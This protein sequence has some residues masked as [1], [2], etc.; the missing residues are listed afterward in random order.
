MGEGND[1]QPSLHAT[2]LFQLNEPFPESYKYL[3]YG[4][5]LTLP[6]FLTFLEEL[7]RD[8]GVL[9]FV[10]Y[11]MSL[12]FS[13]GAPEDLET[14]G[15]V[16]LR[17]ERIA[18][19]VGVLKSVPKNRSTEIGYEFLLLSLSALSR[20]VQADEM[21]TVCTVTCISHLLS[22]DPTFSHT[23]SHSSNTGVSTLPLPLPPTH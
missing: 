19:I 13:D 14:E 9:L 12:E 2:R 1:S 11:D 6:S 4:P 18:G 5:F 16:G 7:R 17:E 3:P 8:E 20:C 15:G 10:V 21:R 23:R 22:N